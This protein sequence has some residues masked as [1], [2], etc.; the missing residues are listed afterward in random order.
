MLQRQYEPNV[1]RSPFDP[2]S[3]NWW[4]AAA[5]DD[6]DDGGGGSMLQKLDGFETAKVM[7]KYYLLFELLVFW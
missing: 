1:M 3:L 2:N 4:Q 5:Y 6:V 7:A